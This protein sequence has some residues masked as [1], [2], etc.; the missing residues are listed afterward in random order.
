MGIVGTD[1]VSARFGY[2]LRRQVLAVAGPILTLRGARQNDRAW[3]TR[4]ASE[5]A[6]TGSDMHRRFSLVRLA[7]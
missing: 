6:L 2:M 7:L 1:P 3:L 5:L 4:A